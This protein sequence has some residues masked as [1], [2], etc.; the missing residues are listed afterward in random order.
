MCSNTSNKKGRNIKKDKKKLSS[1]R[2]L[3]FIEDD[4][5]NKTDII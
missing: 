5:D 2:S 3:T 1:Y 4:I